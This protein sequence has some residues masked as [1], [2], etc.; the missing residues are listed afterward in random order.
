MKL[1]IKLEE[2]CDVVT[3]NTDN[4]LYV[5]DMVNVKRTYN[6]FERFLLSYPKQENYWRF[7]VVFNNDY[8]EVTRD[9]LGD[10]TIE[11]ERVLEVL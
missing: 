8:L 9:D 2:G 11:Y 4:I 6:L 1:K 3:I 7:R 10:L 5:T